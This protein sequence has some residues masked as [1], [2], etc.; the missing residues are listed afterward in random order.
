M[1]PDVKEEKVHS[2]ESESPGMELAL[3]SFSNPRSQAGDVTNT[4]LPIMMLPKLGMALIQSPV[5]VQLFAA[6]TV[7]NIALH[8]FG[9]QK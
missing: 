5:S 9:L 2:D 7:A 3:P 6:C 8:R 4:A 1:Q